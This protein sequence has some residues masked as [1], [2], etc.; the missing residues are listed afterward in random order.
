MGTYITQL[1]L[2]GF[3]MSGLCPSPDQKTEL[4]EGNGHLLFYSRFLGQ[5]LA[6]AF[7]NYLLNKWKMFELE[8]TLGVGG[9]LHPK[10]CHYRDI[11]EGKRFLK[12]TTEKEIKNLLFQVGV[13][14]VLC[15]RQLLFTTLNWGRT[16]VLSGGST[17]SSE[18]SCNL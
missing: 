7:N 3:C 2:L 14:A 16:A 11:R 12:S 8:G 18:T 17:A 5:C 4:F 6:L 10:P 9:T 1:V 15:G 13:S